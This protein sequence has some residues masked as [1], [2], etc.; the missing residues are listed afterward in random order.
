MVRCTDVNDQVALARAD[1]S[2]VIADALAANPGDRL[3]VC[4]GLGAL[5]KCL[6]PDEH[7]TDVQT[8]RRMVQTC[9]DAIGIHADLIVHQAAVRLLKRHALSNHN[10]LLAPQAIE[11]V[12]RATRTFPADDT[13]Q[14]YAA[15]A[16]VGFC[17]IEPA[18]VARTFG[19]SGVD[20]LSQAAIAV[21]MAAPQPSELLIRGR[22]WSEVILSLF[23]RLRSEAQQRVVAQ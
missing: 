1:A 3:T 14:F 22:P 12:Q 2:S 11:A 6:S 15:Q 23:P 10:L 9:M 5:D 4:A 19:Q 20:L 8:T 13:I 21:A 17:S 16:V 18:D 7:A